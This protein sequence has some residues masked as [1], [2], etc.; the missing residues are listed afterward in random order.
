MSDLRPISL[1]SVIYKIVSKVLRARLKWFLPTIV[2][3]TQG[4]FVSG[5]LISDNILLTHEMVYTLSTNPSCDEDFHAIKTDMSKP[6]DRMECNFLEELLIRLGF[7][8]RWV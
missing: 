6:Y 7:D 4:A 2:S 3:D 1:G 8:M 5:R